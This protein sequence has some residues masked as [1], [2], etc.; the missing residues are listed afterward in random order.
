MVQETAAG[1]CLGNDGTEEKT[2][3]RT[4]LE[5]KVDWRRRWRNSD[6]LGRRMLRVGGGAGGGG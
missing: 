5:M 2:K 4:V 3:G 6:C 1:A